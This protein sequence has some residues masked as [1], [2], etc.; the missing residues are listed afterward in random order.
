M[1]FS[2]LIL[3]VM[4]GI[5]LGVSTIMIQEFTISR[6]VKL[7]VPAFYGADAGIER[8]LYRIRKDARFVGVT[9]QGSSGQDALCDAS[10]T[11][12]FSAD[13]TYQASI[14]E[15]GFGEDAVGT[16]PGT[17]ANWC[18]FS[19]GTFQDFARKIRVSF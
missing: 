2:L 12:S 4:L 13:A 6:D 10:A 5:G 7:I 3:S 11:L 15:P 9:C 1:L 16:C 18:I 19:T 17:A 14:Y 8:M